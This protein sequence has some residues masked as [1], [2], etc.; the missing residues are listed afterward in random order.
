MANIINVQKIIDQLYDVSIKPFEHLQ[1]TLG[2]IIRPD[3]DDGDLFYLQTIKNQ[4]EK[5][6]ANIEIIEAANM[7]QAVS[8]I[9]KFR[10]NYRITSIII[11]S[12]Y[13]VE[14]DRVLADMISVRQDID[15][16]S[17]H[18][19]G[20]LLTSTSPIFYRGAPCTVASIY[21]IITNVLPDI[22]GKRIGVVGRSLRVGVPLAIVL[23]KEGATMTVYN[24]TSDLSYLKN[25]DVVV[26]AIGKARF[27][28]GSY[29][30]NGQI[31]IDVGSNKD[32]N[33]CYCGDIDFDSVCDVIGDTGYITPVK[34]GVGKL[35]TTILMSKLFINAASMS[36]EYE[37]YIP[38]KK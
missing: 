34:G 20:K 14:E 18:S 5:F 13:S 33:G 11:L 21:R 9:Q 38:A 22:K 31:V 15:C 30:S 19:M 7:K 27:F 4:C 29:F 12:R 23:T 35:T 25:E 6:G 32:K 3:A 10:N 1:P 8:A 36:G 37:D 17:S 26:S 16:M 2:V 24:S 28:D